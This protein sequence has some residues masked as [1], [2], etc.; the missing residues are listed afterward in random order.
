MVK[1]LTLAVCIGLVGWALFFIADIYDWPPQPKTKYDVKIIS[2]AIELL[3]YNDAWDK[4]DDR[5]C[6]SP[7]EKLSLYCA[8]KKASLDVSGDFHHESAVMEAV[9]DSIIKLQ[10]TQKYQ[11]LLMDYNNSKLVSLK[12]VHQVLE[13]AKVVVQQ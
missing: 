10:P 7:S 8:L 9:R 3:N 12:Q 11:H 4:Q 2:K 13:L 5:H 1:K 6:T